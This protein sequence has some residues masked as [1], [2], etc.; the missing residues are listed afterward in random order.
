MRDNSHITC[1]ILA[2]LPEVALHFRT[3][4]SCFLTGLLL[5]PAPSWSQQTSGPKSNLV[6]ESGTLKLTV[7]EGE[8]ALN[9]IKSRSATAPVVEVHDDKDKPVVGAE[10]VF[11]LPASGPGGVFN[12]WMRTQTTRTND[13][14]RASATGMTP[15]DEEGRFNIKVTATAGKRTGSIIVAQVNTRSGGAAGSQATK[16]HKTLW[17][18]LGVLAAGGIAGGV[19]GTRG[20]SS[21]S[22]S[23]TPV[24][25]T[26]GPV[27][28]GSP[29]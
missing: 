12:G 8:G 21:S 28:V 19:A 26:P 5:L 10:V 14:G 18:V 13:Q 22:T 24:T 17:I 25:I 23:T 15:N 6:E 16:S 7:V 9:H 4:L 2:C 29:H 27:S 3:F 11:Q 1:C 20:G